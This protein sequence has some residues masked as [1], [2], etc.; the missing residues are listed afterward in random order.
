MSDA[1]PLFRG[2]IV[3]TLTPLTRDE[4]LDVDALE[5]HLGF[6]IDAGVDALFILGSNGE[7]AMLRPR[8]RH[9]VA[10]EAVRIA[11]G[12][13]PVIAGALEVS[14]RQVIDEVRELAG[15][16]I[17]G[18]VAT[19]PLYFDGFS[20]SDL[21]DHFNAIAS[22]ADAPILIYNVPQFAA[23]MSEGLIRRV[24]ELPNVA[25]IKDSSGNWTVFQSLVL[26]RP[27]DA[28][29]ILQGFHSQSAVSLFTGCDGLVP[30]YANLYPSLLVEMVACAG[31]GRWSDALRLQRQ[32]DQ[33]LSFRGP[34][35]IHANKTI[36]KALGLMDDVVTAP[37]PRLDEDG[38]V[39]LLAAS[40]A[41][42]LPRPDH[43]AV[44]VA[45]PAA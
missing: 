36:A 44:T 41:A 13:V 35:S 25:G 2:V 9:D 11:A 14:T 22:A 6:V 1:Q 23:P 10:R 17:A 7:G 12:R 20:E 39:Q 30:G 45:G 24:A 26:N 29:A 42:G 33:L 40:F 31:A 28:F 37:L 19:T 5:R 15:V 27:N 43:E 18:F 8:V 3:P 4:E 34:A 21:I 16:G 38:C 32:L